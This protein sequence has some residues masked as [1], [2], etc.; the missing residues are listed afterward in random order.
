VSYRA[1]QR[2]PHSIARLREID[3]H[4]ASAELGG[5]L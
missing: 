5:F 2:D 3:Y 1:V 4:L